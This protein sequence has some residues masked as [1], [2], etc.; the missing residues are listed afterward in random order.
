MALAQ[1]LPSGMAAIPLNPGIVNTEMLR[2]AFGESSSSYPA[3]GE[4]AKVAV[5]FLLELGPKDNGKQMTV[6]E[7]GTV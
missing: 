1:E 6:P 2:S 3:A 5:P 7:L 4:W